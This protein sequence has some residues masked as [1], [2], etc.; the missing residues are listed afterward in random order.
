MA[1]IF[2]SYSSKDRTQAE[3]LIEVLGSAG[4]SVW[5]DKSGIDLA[6]NWSKE[7]VQAIDSCHVFL[8]LLSQHSVESQNVLKEVSLAAEQKKKIL[9]LDVEA[10]A[11]PEDLRYHLAGIQRASVTN[12][13]AIIRTLKKVGLVAIPNLTPA[14]KLVKVKGKRKSLMILPFEDISPAGDNQWF[15]DGIVTE[16]IGVLTNIKS[17]RVTDQQTTKEYKSYKGQLVVFAREMNIRYFVQ[18]SIRKF[19]DQIKISST[20]LDIETG[21]HLWQDSLK[22]TMQDIFDIQEKVAEHVVAGLKLHLDSDERKKLSEHGT[23]NAEA[24]ELFLK[25]NEYFGFQ[26]KR[27]IEHAI[28]LIGEALKLDPMYANA[29]RTKA[30]DLTA[31]YRNYDPDPALLEEAMQLV[32]E[33]LRLQPDLWQAHHALTNIYQL[34]GKL[35]EA[36][37][38]A[39]QFVRNAPNDFM[40]H[41]SLGLFYNYTR[42]YAK[43]IA[44]FEDGLKLN[45]TNLPAIFNLIHACEYSNQVEKRI[46]WSERALPLYEKYLM[47][48]PQDEDKFVRRAAV[49]HFA[50]RDEE[51][52]EAV[53]RLENISD[54]NTLYNLACVQSMLNE[55]QQSLVTFRKAIEAGFRNTGLMREF[56]TDPTASISTLKDSPEHT[57]V[58][59]LV[60]SLETEQKAK[61]HSP[62]STNG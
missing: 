45:A 3:Q 27:S 59:A 16:L 31:L 12:I 18:G 37:E 21:E 20:L 2:I 34:Q 19:G 56:L 22:G 36:E 35:Q 11:L 15:A 7:I 46:F 39:K 14:V 50:G 54:G 1:D 61:Q 49:L 48:F 58:M 24:Y 8:V 43:S 10:V 52:R 25:S 40:S 32:S 42:Q 13:D 30:H 9:P 23:E 28:R 26:T 17:L 44:A 4:Y 41:F 5:I 33:A 38:V 62:S 55:H 6:A 47:L 57:E 29:Y 53:H 51:A 60:E